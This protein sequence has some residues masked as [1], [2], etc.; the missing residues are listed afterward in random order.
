[1]LYCGSLLSVWVFSH[2][3]PFDC[4]EN[5]NNV[6]MIT[7]EKEEGTRGGGL[8]NNLVVKSPK[9]NHNSM[10]N[11]KRRQNCWPAFKMNYRQSEEEL[12]LPLIYYNLLVYKQNFGK[13][14]LA[15]G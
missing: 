4:F 15:N 10:Y 14:K 11:V 2:S 5:I 3:L 7:A 13:Q 12:F 1:M 9:Y 8:K 6:K